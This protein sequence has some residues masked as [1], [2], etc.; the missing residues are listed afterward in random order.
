MKEDEVKLQEK[1]WTAQ[2]TAGPGTWDK[3][4]SYEDGKTVLF[5]FDLRPHFENHLQVKCRIL[6][7]SK[8]DC[9]KFPGRSAEKLMVQI[10]ERQSGSH[11]YY[12]GNQTVEMIWY[13]NHR[14]G[15]AE[16]KLAPIYRR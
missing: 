14:E 7:M 2:V 1:D 6:G 9:Q 16:M 11:S 10:Y 4:T 5:T 13:T 12:L 3:F 8:F 15:K